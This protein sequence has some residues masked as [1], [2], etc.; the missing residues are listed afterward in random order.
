MTQSWWNCIRL[1]LLS[2]SPP[3]ENT[4][5]ELHHVGFIAPSS[6]YG[7]KGVINT[8]AAWSAGGLAPFHIFR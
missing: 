6:P 4:K 8:P 5:H 2:A 1:Y 7:E 3:K